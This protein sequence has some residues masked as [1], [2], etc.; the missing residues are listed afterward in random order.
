MHPGR[1]SAHA[2]RFNPSPSSANT[3]RTSSTAQSS[4]CRVDDERR[5]EA[6]HRAVRVLAEQAARE[7]PLADARA[8]ARSGSISTPISSPLPRTSRDQPDARSLQSREQLVA[9]LARALGQ[10]LV[11]QQVE[12]RQ[13][14][15][16]GERVP[17]K[18]L[19]WSP[20]VNTCITS[21]RAEERGHRQQSAAQRLAEDHAV[22]PDAFVLAGEEAA[23]AAEAGLD[24]V[25]D[26]QHVA[27]RQ[28]ARTRAR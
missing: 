8:V 11:E 9:E 25:A 14:D 5:R 3:A 17:P 28:I 7:Q 15:R 21:A 13:R 10:A 26:Q 1:V 23:G 18:V 24:F 4:S 19:P 12:R 16:R 2:A 20:G 22:G 27:A 6:H